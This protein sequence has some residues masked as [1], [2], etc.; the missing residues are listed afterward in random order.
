MKLQ[1]DKSSTTLTDEKKKIK[2]RTE[3]TFVKIAFLHI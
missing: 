3:V 1:K 2:K